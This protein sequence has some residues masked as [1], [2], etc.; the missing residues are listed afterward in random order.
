M[1]IVE[2]FIESNKLNTK[3]KNCFCNDLCL[4]VLL[5]TNPITS[6]EDWQ[7][8]VRKVVDREIAKLGEK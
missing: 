2:K 4:F 7:N 6:C 5:K 8:R 1:N 3:C